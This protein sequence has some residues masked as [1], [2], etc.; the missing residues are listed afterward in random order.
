M[1]ASG[2][3]ALVVRSFAAYTPFHVAGMLAVLHT[4]VERCLD[5]LPC[6]GGDGFL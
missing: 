2:L 5:P 1:A 3:R 4:D 6:P